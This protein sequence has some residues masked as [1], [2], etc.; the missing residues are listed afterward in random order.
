MTTTDP[1]TDRRPWRAETDDQ[2]DWALRGLARAEQEAARLRAAAARDIAK[3]KEWLEDHLPAAQNEVGR[4]EARVADFQRRRIETQLDDMGIEGVPSVD[5]WKKVKLKRYPLP[6]GVAKVERR[7]TAIEIVDANAFVAWADANGRYDL[8][9]LRPSK[10]ALND[11][12]LTLDE[13]SR[14]VLD[15]DEIVPGLETVPARLVYGASA[16]KDEQPAWL[17]P[18]DGVDPDD[19]L[20]ESWRQ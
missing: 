17:P 20:D 7:A 16:T 10:S 6:S 4:W 3:V 5:A 1:T 9:E 15:G 11:A 14:R 13:V 2:V 19:E 8:L 12:G 18:P